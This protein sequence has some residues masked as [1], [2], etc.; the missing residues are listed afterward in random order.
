MYDEVIIVAVVFASIIAIAIV[1]GIVIYF[2]KRLEHKQIM[3]AIE[4][5]IPLPEIRP[6]R[7]NGVSWVRS[8]TGGIIIVSLALAFVFAGPYMDGGPGLFVAIIL[9]GVGLSCI[10]RGLLYRKYTVH[11]EQIQSPNKNNAVEN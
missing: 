7:C 6:V 3:A 11:G 8:L 4:K 10:V 9:F 1:I 2:A 5:G